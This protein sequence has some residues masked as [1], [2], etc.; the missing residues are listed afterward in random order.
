MDRVDPTAPYYPNSGSGPNPPSH[1]WVD[2][3]MFGS[4]LGLIGID[5]RST[6]YT[7][8][9]LGLDHEPYSP[10]T[11]QVWVRPKLHRGGSMSI[12]FNIDL[13]DLLR[14][15]PDPFAS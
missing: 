13:A 10:E 3:V 12:P 5:S 1:V 8:M 11:C 7:N 2:Q 15:R 4:D 14:P 9:S 6:T